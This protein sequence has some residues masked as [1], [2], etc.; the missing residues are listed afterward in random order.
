MSKEDTMFRSRS[1]RGQVPAG[2]ADALSPRFSDHELATLSRLGTVVDVPADSVLMAQD[3]FGRE[4][5]VLVA[6]RA[7]VLRDGARVATI[8]TG[9]IVGEISILTGA[10]RSATVIALEDMRV[11]ALTPAEFNSLMTTCPRLEQ[12]VLLDA[13]SRVA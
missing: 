13:V 3:T 6:G 10:R 5:L 2:I 1:A 12:R 8:E 4:V 7:E 11:Y 9:D